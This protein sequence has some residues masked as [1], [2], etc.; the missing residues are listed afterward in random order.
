LRSGCADMHENWA[1]VPR[2]SQR[3][4]VIERSRYP[5][6]KLSERTRIQISSPLPDNFGYI[7]ANSISAEFLN[8]VKTRFI[9]TQGP[10]E[11]TT[12]EFWEMVWEQ[13]SSCIV[14][15]TKET[16]FGRPKCYKYWTDDF[17][18]VRDG[19]TLTYIGEETFVDEDSENED[20]TIVIRSFTMFDSISNIHRDI[21]QVQYMDWLDQSVPNSMSSFNSFFREYRRIKGNLFLRGSPIV[22]HC[23]A[24]VG[25]TGVFVALDLLIEHCDYMLNNNNENSDTVPCVDVPT[26]VYEMRKQ[27]FDVITNEKQYAFV[28][29]YLQY[30][31]R[32]NLFGL[33][34]KNR[35]HNRM[36][37]E[38]SF[39]LRSSFKMK[40]QK[41]QLSFKK[42]LQR[43]IVPTRKG[44][45][46]AN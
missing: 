5:E 8:G 13:K 29:L 22:V 37:P 34:I 28:Y 41:K 23:S 44:K 42:K 24:G 27:R 45:N 31:L 7:N 12:L 43:R 19:L 11:K 30:C 6:M 4:I 25:R 36:A 10:T 14:M 16:E 20:V 17:L 9:A 18:E 35:S 26:T 33:E 39:T 46:N 1:F 3:H 40:V 2:N 32:N 38:A 15:L 21:T